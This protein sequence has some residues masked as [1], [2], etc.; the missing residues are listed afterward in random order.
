M[1]RFKADLNL[2]L[3]FDAVYA[4]RNL[5]RAARLLHITQP[6]V[7]NA[8]K[9][10]RETFG[11]ALFVRT[12]RGVAPTPVADHVAPRIKEAL[13]L[14]GSSLTEGEPFAPGAASRAF[15]LG[16]HDIDEAI[17]LPRLMERL[18][19]LAPG[20]SVEC[21]EVPRRELERELASGELDF[22]LDVPLF[23]VPQ[24]CRQQVSTERYVCVVRPGHPTAAGT[25][26]LEAYLALEHVHVSTR[27]R[28]VGHVDMALE[29][30]GRERRIQL[31][32]KSYMA[33]P[34]VVAS[35]DLALTIPRALA[36]LYDLAILELPFAVDPLVQYLYWHRS[37]DQDRANLWMR[38]VLLGLLEPH[39]LDRIHS[40]SGVAY[41]G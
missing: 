17:L 3:V 31:R 10:L 8:L 30:L 18:G 27:R 24:L 11:D 33:A 19:R 4:E 28:G 1:S 38:G 34:Q 26:T 25:L 23:S 21:Y 40:G 6:A 7:S 5:T 41:R 36:A 22:A 9:R 39:L 15:S 29:Q 16:M 32:M 14:L 13:K 37:A 20:V 35:T 12:P 2:F